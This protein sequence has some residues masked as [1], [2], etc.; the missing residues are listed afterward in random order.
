[1]KA[2]HD[3]LTPP[4]LPSWLSVSGEALML[5]VHAQP[6]A[7]R[8]AVVSEHGGRLKIALLAPP[9]EGRANAALVKF[10]AERLAVPRAAIRIEAGE[11]SREK[12]LR[13]SGLTAD[14]LIGRL[15]PDKKKEQV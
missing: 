10:L 14:Q 3:S 1:M 8:A 6:G 9:L 11:S 15:A 5:A 7:R 13:V 4:V 2:K 12:R